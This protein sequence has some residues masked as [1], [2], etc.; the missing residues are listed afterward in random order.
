MPGTFDV[1][2]LYSV[3]CA[4]SAFRIATAP[5][6]ASTPVS[7]IAACAIL[8]CTVTSICRQPLCAVTTW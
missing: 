2:C 4:Y 6:S 8:P 1:T 7:G 5:C 3:F